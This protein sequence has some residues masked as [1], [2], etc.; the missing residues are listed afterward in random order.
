M[1]EQKSSNS[2]EHEIDEEKAGALGRSG[3]KLRAALDNL[4]RFDRNRAGVQRADP[5]ARD[6]LLEAASDAFWL[7]VVQREALGLND[8]EYIC[9]EYGVPP[10]GCGVG[11][12]RSAPHRLSH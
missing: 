10:Q 11:P 1:T 3:R 6:K 4:Q 9:Q 5:V 12:G 2:I 7:Y 8:P